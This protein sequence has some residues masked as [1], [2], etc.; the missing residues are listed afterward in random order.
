MPQ[1]ERRPARAASAP[2]ER[3]V[4]LDALRRIVRAILRGANEAE[5]RT[6]VSG[7]QLFVLQQL[8]D[9]PARSM[10]DI[11]ARTLTHQSTVSV[12]VGRLVRK[13]LVVRQQDP[14]DRRRVMLALSPAG[15]ALLRR[16]PEPMQG[17]LIESIARIPQKD[18]RTV[19]R[20]LQMIV[21]EVGAAEGRPA[22]FL[23]ASE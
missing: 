18:L 11:A 8:A 15:R 3:A 13:G 6:G 21:R 1:P 7:A 16:A 2:R 20:N 12:V 22:M 9:G 5:K 19:A 4:V 17:R 23:E 14:A 10:R